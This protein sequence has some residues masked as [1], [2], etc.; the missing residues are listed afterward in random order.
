[1]QKKDQIIFLSIIFIVGIIFSF[2]MIKNNRNELINA[3]KIR[4]ESAI[5]IDVKSISFERNGLYLNRTQYNSGGISWYSKF[6]S[7]DTVYSFEDI[8]PPFILQ[9]SGGSDSLNIFKNNEKL[10][11]L[12]SKELR[13]DKLDYEK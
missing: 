12:I 5:N 8:H 3:S 10:Y 1:M 6:Y 2:I 13:F 9:K 4:K 7:N 11:L